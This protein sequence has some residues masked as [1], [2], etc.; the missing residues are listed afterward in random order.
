MRTRTFLI[1]L[2]MLAATYLFAQHKML[3]SNPYIVT[4]GEDK[5]DKAIKRTCGTMAYLEQQKA[6]YPGLEQRMALIEQQTKQWIQ[7]HPNFKKTGVVITI[8][9]V[10]HVVWKTTTQNISDA[11]IIS[12]IDVLNEDYRRLNA[13][14]SNTPSWFTSVAADCEI[15]FCLAVRDPLGNS[16]NGI[17]R[18]QTSV[19]SWT[20]DDIKYTSQGGEDAWPKNDYLNI[21]VGNLGGGLLGWATF[22]GGLAAEDGVVIHY[23]AFGRVGTLIPTFNKGRTTTHE[24]GHWLALYHTFS[25]G[26]V[27]TS[28]TNCITQGDRVCDTP[29]TS[30]SNFGC[31]ALTQNTCTETPVDQNDMTSNFMDY[32]D[33]ACMNLFTQGQKTRMMAVLNGSRLSIQSSLGCVP[34]NALD[35]SIS[36]IVSPPTGTICA[37]SIT[38]VVTLQNFGSNTLSSVTINYDM[39]TGPNNTFN[40]T[41]SLT[42]SASEQITLTTMAVSAGS[43]IFNAS[44][45]NPN[46]G[47]DGNTSNDASLQ[48]FIIATPSVGVALPLIEGIENITFPPAGWTLVDPNSNATWT[49]VTNASGFGNSTASSRMYFFSSTEDIS[50]QSDYLYTP[51]ID[52]SGAASPTVMDFNVAYARYDATYFDSLIIWASS[53]CGGSWTRIWQ[54]G[55]TQLATAPDNSSSFTPTNAQWRAETINLDSYIGVPNLQILFEAKSGWGNNLF[56]DDINISTPVPVAAFTA[57]TTAVCAGENV[58]FTDQ[59]TGSPASWSW[60]FQGGAPSASTAQNPTVA[61]DTAGIYDVTLIV[62]NAN[63]SDTLTLTNYITVNLNPSLITIGTDISCNGLCDGQASATVSGGSP[64]YTYL[65]SNG[66][67]TSID[68]GLCGGTYNI[69]VTDVNGC[70]VIDNVTIA[71]PS[72]INLLPSG[73]DATCGASDGSAAVNVTGG[74]PGYTYLWSSG[75]TDSLE[76]NLAVGNYSITVTDTNGCVE[77]VNVTVNNI[78][79]PGLSATKTDISCSGLCD[80][81]AAVNVSGGVSPYTYSWSPAGGTDSTASNLC[82]GIFTVTVTD[83]SNCIATANVTITEPAAI[84]IGPEVSTGLSCFGSTDGTITIIASGGTGTLNYSID[85]GATFTNTTGN[86]TSL[87]AGTYNVMVKD[88]NNCTQ[89]GSILTITEPAAIS[90]GPE[91]STDLSCFGS[92]DGTITIIAS[93]GTG[94][95]NYSIDSGATFTNTTGNFT[96]LNAGIYNVMVKDANNCTQPGSTLTITEPAAITAP[97]ILFTDDTN[98]S[99]V[100]TATIFVSGGTPSYTYSWAP[101]GGIDSVAV[102]LTAGTYTVIVTDVN[103]CNYMDSVIVGNI[104]GISELAVTDNHIRFYPN[105]TNGNITLEIKNLQT[106]N[107]AIEVFN[108]L[109][110]TVYSKS[111]NPPSGKYEL[112]LSGLNNGIYFVRIKIDDHGFITKVILNR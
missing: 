100:G 48:S 83:D 89:S 71:E 99:D 37:D 107:L 53:D 2:F 103:G 21:W 23:S 33:D 49:R 18:T 69:T 3:K 11:Q 51:E 105:P 5:K 46:G 75:G 68:T 72:A 54:K 15:E 28:S 85:S 111:Y 96:S 67:T 19:T 64:G 56:I 41:G 88:A 94:T 45:S 101:F 92:N 112:N 90:I 17:T 80:G 109:G 60:T 73:T 40:W 91:V 70:M 110:N 86:F 29:P 1:V 57:S 81:N 95:L 36:A 102:G 65:W 42:T 108:I 87:N 26:C 50:G 35:A 93:G 59:S 31:P 44:T 61:Y 16:T 104:T 97:P 55:N 39:D 106:G 98:G 9:V 10:V 77:I 47:A 25:G 84:S 58:N 13:D 78:G 66:Q 27:G 22:P 14:T 34:L 12:Q 38:P 52:L 63:G 4:K 24:I 8:P 7:H 79:A 30:S 74:T 43:H 76:T 6:K 20:N 62:T 82:A 32:T